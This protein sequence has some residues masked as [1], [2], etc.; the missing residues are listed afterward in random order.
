MALRL[1]AFNIGLLF[2]I[3]GGSRGPDPGSDLVGQ[4]V[5]IASLVGSH[6]DLLFDWF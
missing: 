2:G 6:L 1:A 5:D 4:S 3:F